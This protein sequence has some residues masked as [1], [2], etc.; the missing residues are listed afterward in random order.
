MSKLCVRE[1]CGRRTTEDGR[2][3]RTGV[4]SKKQEP[5]TNMWRKKIQLQPNNLTHY[6]I[7]KS[8]F[9]SLKKCLKTSQAMRI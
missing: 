6:F 8:K 3:G 5:H 4:H 2:D 7:E 9:E 1:L